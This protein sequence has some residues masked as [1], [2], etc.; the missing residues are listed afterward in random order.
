MAQGVAETNLVGVFL[1]KSLTDAEGYLLLFS[2]LSIALNCAVVS[3]NFLLRRQ[4]HTYRSLCSC[5]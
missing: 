4:P 3:Q 5:Q 1:D 2:F